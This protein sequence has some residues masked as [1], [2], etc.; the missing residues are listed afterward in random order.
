MGIIGYRFRYRFRIIILII[1]IRTLI[2]PCTGLAKAENY[3]GT[4]MSKTKNIKYNLY[5]I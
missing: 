3:V 1:I 4:V 2:S 5:K